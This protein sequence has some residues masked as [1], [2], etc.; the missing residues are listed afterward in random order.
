[1]QV[2][3]LAQQK[4]VPSFE[5]VQASADGR[6]YN[7][8]PISQTIEW[9]PTLLTPLE[10]YL[11]IR[12]GDHSFILETAIHTAE[13]CQY[14]NSVIGTEPYQITQTAEDLA[15]EDG[16]DLRSLDPLIDLERELAKYRVDPQYALE[17]PVLNGGAVGYVSYDCVKYFE[18]RVKEA[19]KLSDDLKIPET[20]FLFCNSFVYLDHEKSCL[21]I[22][23]LCSLEGDLEA[24]YKLASDRIH[25]LFRRVEGNVSEDDYTSITHNQRD[26]GTSNYGEEGY[27]GFVDKLKERI[28]DGDIIQCVPSHRITRSTG[29]HP[30]QIYKSLRKLNP[31]PYMFY[32]DLKD[33]HILGCSP[34]LLVKVTDGK[35][36]N[37]P[38]AGTRKRGANKEED[39]ALRKD[40][41]S[42]EKEISEHVML[43]DLGRNDVNRVAVPSSTKVDSLMHIELYSH[44]MHIVSH[45]SGK[46]REGL[47]SF[48]AFRS[49]FPAG[50]L[51]GAPKVKSMEFISQLE[52]CK[53]GVYGGAVGYFS[54]FRGD[55]DTCIAIRS[56]LHKDGKAYLQAGGG[57]VYDSNRD[58]EYVETI[59][60]MGATSKAVTMAEDDM[61]GMSQSDRRT[62]IVL[63]S[64][65]AA[66]NESF[67]KKFVQVEKVDLSRDQVHLEIKL[68]IARGFDTERRKGGILMIDNYDSFTWNLYQYLSQLGQHVTVIRNDQITV[69]ECLQL[70]PEKVVISPGPSWPKDA[71]ISSDVMRAFEGKVPIL[72]VCLGLEC[73]YEVYGGKITHCGEIKHGK[74]SPITHDGKGVFS[75]IPQNI[76]VTRYHSLAAPADKMPSVIEVTAQTSSGIVM[77]MRHKTYTV[78]G[79][80]FH[81]ESIKTDF[82]M[83]MLANFLKFKGGKWSDNN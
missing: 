26:P 66:Y 47:T 79:V 62:P 17:P 45:V 72:G 51:S 39:E 43:V 16:Q 68:K 2:Q 77:G 3:K 19:G 83:E 53:R 29:V 78:E 48:D 54:F 8:I 40:L 69:E 67:R 81:P 5:D 6:R 75:G 60:K 11:R 55:A 28:A 59:N 12:R 52:K 36:A 4:T 57:I 61:F 46:L 27:K 76:P 56:M 64:S 49:I 63:E 25:E 21:Q 15:Q 20:L 74:T 30:F 22:V 10:C 44:V 41:L 71:G 82:G 33:F 32:M 1:M 65:V 38:I 58:D 42:D 14:R 13:G 35:I 7:L 37:H 23:A 9:D 34:E 31:S 18:P 73:M 24:N 80:Q 70:E 50:T